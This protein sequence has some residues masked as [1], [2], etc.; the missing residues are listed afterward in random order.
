MLAEFFRRGIKK[1][2]VL[3]KTAGIIQSLYQAFA[4]MC[5]YIFLWEKQHENQ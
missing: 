5:T 1:G 2:G 4:V 3:D